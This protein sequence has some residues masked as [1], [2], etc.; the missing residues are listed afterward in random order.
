MWRGAS[1]TLDVLTL[2]LCELALLD[3][4]LEGLVEHGIKLGFRGCDDFVVGPDIFLDGLTAVWWAWLAGWPQR[5]CDR[6]DASKIEKAASRERSLPAPIAFLELSRRTCQHTVRS[7]RPDNWFASRRWAWSK[8]K[9]QQ[10]P[11]NRAAWAQTVQTHVEDSF[12]DHI[13]NERSA[14]L[15][16]RGDDL[17]ESKCSSGGEEWGK[18]TFV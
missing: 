14:L 1:P 17:S 2:W 11:D 3:T 16:D 6:G 4:G 10:S 9:V 12:L 8:P 5:R 15:C 13:W 7:S 18:Q